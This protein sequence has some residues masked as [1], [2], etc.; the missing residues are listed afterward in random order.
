MHAEGVEVG[1]VVTSDLERSDEELD[2]G[3]GA[4]VS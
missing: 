1:D 4:K 2:L 3:D